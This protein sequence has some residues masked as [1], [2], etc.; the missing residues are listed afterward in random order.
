MDMTKYKCP[1][2][3]CKYLTDNKLE[4]CCGQAMTEIS[5]EEAKI[6]QSE[7]SGGKTKDDESS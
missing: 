1:Q 5:D 2:K 3:D 6:I 7:E 4:K